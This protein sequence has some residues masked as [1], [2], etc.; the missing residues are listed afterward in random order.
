[1]ITVTRLK[2]SVNNPD[3]P[4]LL[5]DGT[6][7][8]FYV[9]NYIAKM[10][11]NEYNLSDAQIAALNAFVESGIASGWAQ[12]VKY[13]LPCVG[14][15]STPITGAIPLIDK[16]GNYE[17]SEYDGTEDLSKVFAGADGEIKY[18]HQSG[19]VALKT[20][21]KWEDLANSMSVVFSRKMQADP[22]DNYNA[23]LAGCSVTG[24]EYRRI[25][26]RLQKTAQQIYYKGTSEAA[27]IV[28]SIRP[29]KS[30]D[31]PDFTPT[32]I[33]GL[34]SIR[35]DARTGKTIAARSFSIDGAAPNMSSGDWTDDMEIT[36]AAFGVNV[37][38]FG[39]GIGS[40]TTQRVLDD[41]RCIGFFDPYIPD[42]MA[43]RLIA[44]IDALCSALGK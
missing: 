26:L 2:A 39:I 33:T 44:D 5:D 11:S 43:S 28:R 17:M 37:Q 10:R 19:E 23:Y 20:P 27:S 29:V 32:F 12:Y 35:V 8:N 16:V 40:T 25:A 30:Q 6:V 13:F 42:N 3:L 31:Y 22:A 38:K 36:N 4:V 24:G 14:S 15:L 41:V 21:V 1:M 9:G 7:V 34:W 18:I